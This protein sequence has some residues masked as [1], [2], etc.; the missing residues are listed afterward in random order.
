MKRASFVVGACLALI[1]CSDDPYQDF[2]HPVSPSSPPPPTGFVLFGTVRGEDGLPVPGA[3]AEVVAGRDS[4]QSVVSNA[5]GYFR[6]VGVSG[7][8]TVR[9]YKDGYDRFLQ[10]F[11]V[12]ADLAFEVKLPRVELADT[13]RLGQTVQASVKSDAPPCD[14]IRWDARAPCRTFLITPRTS[15]LLVVTITWSGGPE[16]DATLVDG[17]GEYVA[18]S[19]DVPGEEVSLAAGLDA[20]K[21][22]VLRVNSYYSGQIFLVRAEFQGADAP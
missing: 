13:L 16:L 18:Y 11:N 1:A 2:S 4:G 19:N 5:N 22:Y 17:R 15:G 12:D 10:T 9:V 14:P 20:G 8:L 7:W 21:T 3:T 6:F